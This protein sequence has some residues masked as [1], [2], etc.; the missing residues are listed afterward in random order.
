MPES[1]E[2]EPVPP[3][4]EVDVA[5]PLGGPS[6]AAGTLP[7]WFLQAVVGVCAVISAVILL[8]AGSFTIVLLFMLTFALAMPSAYVW[9]RFAEGRRAATDK[10]VTVGIVTG[11]GLAVAPL[12]SLLYEFVKR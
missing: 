5:L 10:L 6:V 1:H 12:I 9:S 11:F 4:A 8:A 2:F 7:S 3:S